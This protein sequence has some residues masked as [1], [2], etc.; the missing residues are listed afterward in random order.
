MKKP[1]L[2]MCCLVLLAFPG[3][4]QVI[5]GAESLAD[6]LPLIRNKNIAIVANP[7]SRVGKTH[8]VDTLVK[9]GVAIEKIFAP[10]H[11][12]RSFE[13]A[14][15]TILNAVDSATR[16]PVISLYGKK[17]KPEKADL[18][19][20]DLVL[21][22]LQDVGVRFF[23][24]ISTL[25]GVMESCARFNIPLIVLDRPNPN[26]FYIDGPVLDSVY[27]SF[28]GM[29]PV[30]VVYGM[31]IGEYAK[32]VNGEGWLPGGMIC[33]LQVIPLKNYTHQ[34]L[35]TLP[36][37]PSPNL[38]NMNAVYLYP[39]LGLFEG[40]I[41]SVGRGTDF[42]FE[43]F[44]HP[45]MRGFAFSF[46]PQV[47]RAGGANPPF[48]GQLCRG[49]DLRNFYSTHPRMF[50]RL[51]LAWL[52][53]AFQDLSDHTDFFS[54]Y[55]EKL[56]GNGKLREQIMYEA[57]EDEIRKGWEPGLSQFR[58]VRAKYLLYP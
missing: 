50:G 57:P 26:G 8:L 55:F 16:I 39:S 20:V 54:S 24:Y 9:S 27:A 7:A 28:V 38:R 21:F 48:K 2:M 19:N 29:H 51:N 25:T 31:T 56:C 44:G 43:V 49:I 41:M 22:D 45:A 36:V 58:A 17:K 47:T 40:T 3:L 30:P 10:E 53:M 15:K 14:G 4:A 33:E 37:P 12:F 5:T 23:T 35:Y 32:M 18:D 34:T 6:Y 42:P 1:I 46:T 13:E 52:R 11:G